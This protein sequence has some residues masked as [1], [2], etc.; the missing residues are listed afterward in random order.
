MRP[1]PRILIL[2]GILALLSAGTTAAEVVLDVESA[3]PG[4]RE[5]IFVGQPLTIRVEGAEGARISVETQPS[6]QVAETRDA[7]RLSEGGELSWT[8]ERAGLV[9]LRVLDEDGAELARRD[10]AVRWPH[11]PLSAL[12]VLVGAGMLLFGGVWLGFGRQVEG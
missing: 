12:A 11:L 4:I 5:G 2:L 6:S 7:G 8:P 3:G 9:R 1:I 10:L